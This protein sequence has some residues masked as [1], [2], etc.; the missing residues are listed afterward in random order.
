M[1]P[2]RTIATTVLSAWPAEHLG[3]A[4]RAAA[5]VVRAS[6]ETIT[7]S[8]SRVIPFDPSVR[9]KDTYLSSSHCKIVDTAGDQSLTMNSAYEH[10]QNTAW[11]GK[12]IQACPFDAGTLQWREWRD[13]FMAYRP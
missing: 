2:A 13:G 10:G 12:H 5:A 7:A 11:R 9:S 1:R 6:P 4:A 3:L 8:S